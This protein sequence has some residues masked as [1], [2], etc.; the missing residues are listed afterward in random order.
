MVWFTKQKCEVL[1]YKKSY[2]IIT[3]GIKDN[4]NGLYKLEISN[5]FF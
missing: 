2:E 4:V 3:I 5:T 1:F